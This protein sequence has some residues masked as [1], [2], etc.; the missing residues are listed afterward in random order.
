MVGEGGGT[1]AKSQC[2]AASGRAEARSFPFED[3]VERAGDGGATVGEVPGGKCGGG[4]VGEGRGGEGGSWEV[5]AAPLLFW[6]EP[7]KDQ[8]DE[9]A[10]PKLFALRRKALGPLVLR[11]VGCSGGGVARGAEV[12]PATEVPGATP[13]DGGATL[14]GR[15]MPRLSPNETLRVGEVPPALWLCPVPIPIPNP[16]VPSSGKK[17]ACSP[18]GVSDPPSLGPGRGRRPTRPSPAWASADDARWRCTKSAACVVPPPGLREKLDRVG[19]GGNAGDG[20]KSSSTGWLGD[21]CVMRVTGTRGG[22]PG[23][24]R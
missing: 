19:L 8:P 23:I 9:D 2:G 12:C 7:G 6:C 18:P 15:E 5:D 14:D 21:G 24:L 11:G 13:V 1:E 20:G 16:S 17:L 22:D 4:R 3:A 10:V